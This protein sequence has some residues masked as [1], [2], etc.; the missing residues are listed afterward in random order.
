[1]AGTA[2]VL[3]GPHRLWG[4]GLLRNEANRDTCKPVLRNTSA[5]GQTVRP[6]KIML[7]SQPLGP[8]NGTLSGNR[9]F[10]DV[11]ELRQGHQAGP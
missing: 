4:F 6:R 10:V 8:K 9:L 7:K 3:A 5:I 11:I 2:A 1:M